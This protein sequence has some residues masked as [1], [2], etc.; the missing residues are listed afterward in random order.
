MSSLFVLSFRICARQAKL[1]YLLYVE[2][3]IM[4]LLCMN[5]PTVQR[6]PN[7]SFKF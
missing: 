6:Q 7:A 1:E 4:L 5:C 3:Q 2:A